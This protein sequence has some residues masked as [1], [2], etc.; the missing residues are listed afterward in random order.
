[1]D[2]RR[3]TLFSRLKGAPSYSLVGSGRDEN[4]S[5]GGEPSIKRLPQPLLAGLSFRTL[6]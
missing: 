5:F 4:G 3:E 6:G 1:V 2:E